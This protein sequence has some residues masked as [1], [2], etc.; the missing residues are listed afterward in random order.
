MR[1]VACQKAPLFFPVLSISG[2]DSCQSDI[3][4][5]CDSKKN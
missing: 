3:D 1:E 5:Q 4:T 2:G